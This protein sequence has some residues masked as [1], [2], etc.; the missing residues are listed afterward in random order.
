MPGS[1]SCPLLM[2]T[3]LSRNRIFAIGKISVSEEFESWK[4]GP[5]PKVVEEWWWGAGGV[6][7][8]QSVDVAAPP[9][10]NSTTFGGSR[11]KFRLW[12][13]WRCGQLQDRGRRLLS[14]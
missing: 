13:L 4:N 10:P 8:T 12:R 9:P 5:E 11:I 14:A 2:S 7:G 6:R 1:F 3:A